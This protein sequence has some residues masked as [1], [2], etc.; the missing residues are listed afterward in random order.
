MSEL[1]LFDLLDEN[2]R[3]KI[4]ALDKALKVLKLEIN[5]RLEKKGEVNK[6][7][8]VAASEEIIK[9]IEGIR[10]LVETVFPYDISSE[11]YQQ[12][13]ISNEDNEFLKSLRAIIEESS[14]KIAK[15]K[16]IL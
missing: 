7:Q 12:V 16:K 8:L 14:E 9:A 1:K 3:E 13:M 4:L 6:E 2:L 15:V 10:N 11:E 5:A